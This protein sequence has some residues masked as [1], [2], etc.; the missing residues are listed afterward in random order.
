MLMAGYYS[1]TNYVL[2]PNNVVETDF[3][4]VLI[5][6]SGKIIAGFPLCDL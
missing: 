5:Q 3:I 4:M 2:R 6:I 1:L